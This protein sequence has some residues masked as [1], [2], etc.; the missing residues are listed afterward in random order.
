[1][2]NLNIESFEDLQRLAQIPDHYRSVYNSAVS[3]RPDAILA[4]LRVWGATSDDPQEIT[5]LINQLINSPGFDINNTLTIE[6]LLFQYKVPIPANI[7]TYMG[8]SRKEPH[9]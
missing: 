5:Q 7:R 6:T 2:F 3:W 1:M 9:R 4:I 8:V